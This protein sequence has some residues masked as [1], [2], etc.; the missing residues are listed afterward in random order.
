MAIQRNECENEEQ[1]NK[2]GRCGMMMAAKEKGG[3]EG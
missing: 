1:L 2:R 3:K